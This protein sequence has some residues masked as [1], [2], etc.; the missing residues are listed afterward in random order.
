MSV[1]TWI[2]FKF[3][4][5]GRS[6]LIFLERSSIFIVCY[7]LSN[8]T[9]FIVLTYFIGMCILFLLTLPTI[10]ISPWKYSKAVCICC[11]SNITTW[12]VSRSYMKLIFDMLIRDKILFCFFVYFMRNFKAFLTR[13]LQTLKYLI[14][15]QIIEI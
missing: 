7:A 1:D 4:P 12:K 11:C 14:W 2:W 15:N 6:L 8:T 13:F 3:R 9:T 5:W 10:F